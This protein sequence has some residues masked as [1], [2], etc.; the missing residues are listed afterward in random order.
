MASLAKSAAPAGYDH[1]FMKAGGT[2]ATFLVEVDGVNIGR[3]SEVSGLQVEV[4]VEQ[5]KEGGVNGFSHHLPGRM[6]WP[7]LVLKRGITYDD[8]LLNW[9]HQTTGEAFV[10]EGKVLRTTAAVTMISSAGKRLRSWN[11]TDA[12]PVRWSGPTFA[13]TAEEQPTEELEVAHHGFEATSFR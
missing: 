12:V 4:E 2:A 9:F 6:T 1:L 13:A 3:F 5:Y 11:L 7:N 10:T 8:N